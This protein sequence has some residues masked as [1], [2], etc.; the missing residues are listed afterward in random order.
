MRTSLL[1]LVC[2]ACLAMLVTVGA[3]AATGAAAMQ[4][5]LWQLPSLLWNFATVLLWSLVLGLCA[6][7]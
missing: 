3:F 2:L 6:A 1:C 7:E 5:C 4:L